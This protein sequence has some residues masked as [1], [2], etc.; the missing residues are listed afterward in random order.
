LGS[1]QITVDGAPPKAKAPGGLDFGPA[2]VDKFHHPF[3]Q[4]QAM[5]FQA[6]KPVRPCANVNVKC[7]GFA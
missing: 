5:G 1:S 6:H 2:G 3:T 4:I 7:Y